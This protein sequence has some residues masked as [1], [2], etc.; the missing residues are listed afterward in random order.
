MLTAL[1]LWAAFSLAMLA[2]WLA[3]SLAGMP[4]APLSFLIDLEIQKTV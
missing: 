3:A 4:A 1:S 2:A